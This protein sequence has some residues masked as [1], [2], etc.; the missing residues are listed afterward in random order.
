MLAACGAPETST[1]PTAAPAQAVGT[2]SDT[3]DPCAASALQVYRLQYNGVLDRWGSAVLIAGQT[4]A[5]DLQAPIDSLQQ[6]ADELNALKP[7]ACAAQAH[8]ETLAAMKMSIG[9]YQDLL[10]KKEVGSTLRTAIDQLAGATAKVAALPGTP[11]PV[12]TA[13]ATATLV[14]TWTPLPTA[15]P[16]A[17]PQPTATPEPR[18]GVIAGRTQMFDSPSGTTPVRTLAKDTA[19]L[20]FELQKSRLHIRVDGV[21]GWVSQGSVIIR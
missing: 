14:P 16:T 11:P 5:P 15:A 8:A 21:D 3:N 1:A 20:V 10:A 19:V 2:T 7:P 18:N 17:T 13:A 4:K 9:G 6:I 12:P